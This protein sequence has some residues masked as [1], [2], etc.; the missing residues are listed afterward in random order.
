MRTA[1]LAAHY[2]ALQ[3]DAVRL[4]TVMAYKPTVDML[5]AEVRERVAGDTERQRLLELLGRYRAAVLELADVAV[6]LRE[7]CGTDA[8]D[9]PPGDDAVAVEHA[10][11]R[12]SHDAER[13]AGGAP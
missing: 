1:Q 4:H 12:R 7:Q 13:R 10:R 8:D 3:L 5:V 11:I 6:S 9:L 2:A